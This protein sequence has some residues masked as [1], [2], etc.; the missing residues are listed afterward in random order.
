LN[1]CIVL[2]TAKL[3]IY[4]KTISISNRRLETGKCTS[5]STVCHKKTALLNTTAA[6]YLHA[7]LNK[8]SEP[9]P[10]D[11][12]PLGF[13][14]PGFHKAHYN[15]RKTTTDVNKQLSE[16]VTVTKSNQPKQ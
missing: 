2:L 5:K 7:V 9:L 11:N 16:L 13:S 6:S 1:I 15:E 8:T 3:T 14:L 10:K 4:S 12:G